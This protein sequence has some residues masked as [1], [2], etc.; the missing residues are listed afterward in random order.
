M[1]TTLAPAPSASTAEAAICAG[2]TGTCSLRPTVSPAP[3]RAVVRMTLLF[4]VSLT[5]DPAFLCGV[6]GR[7]RSGSP[8]GFGSAGVLH[9]LQD[10]AFDELVESASHVVDG[11][12]G[13]AGHDLDAHAV[14]ER[15]QPLG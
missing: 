9:A 3:V 12:A 11:A 10:V 4:M 2:V 15:G 5:T 6:E 8:P 1:C 7:A 13:H 14:D